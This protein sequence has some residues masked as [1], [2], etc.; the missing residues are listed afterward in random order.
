MAKDISEELKELAKKEDILSKKTLSKE[1]SN[2]KK[3]KEQEKIKDDF[4]KIQ[5]DLFELKEK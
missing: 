3:N 2:F 1:I 5:N 4:N